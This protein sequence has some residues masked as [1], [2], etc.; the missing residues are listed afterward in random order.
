MVN[1]PENKLTAT[2]L[3]SEELS[4][5]PPQCVIEPQTK[6]STVILFNQKSSQFFK[7]LVLKLCVTTL[8][9]AV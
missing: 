1:E 9:R 2:C 3:R 6:P 8:W 4:K 7:P 5:G